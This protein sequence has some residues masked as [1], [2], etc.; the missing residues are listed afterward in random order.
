MA[1]I[2]QSPNAQSVTLGNIPSVSLTPISST[3]KPKLIN[4][5]P[6]EKAGATLDAISAANTAFDE[7]SLKA[8]AKL[9]QQIDDANLAEA[10]TKFQID[11]NNYLEKFKRENA[12]GLD[13]KAPQEAYIVNEHLKRAYMGNTSSQKFIKDKLG[14]E[15]NGL[16]PAYMADKWIEKTE[17]FIATQTKTSINYIGTEI[18]KNKKQKYDAAIKQ[19][20][21]EISNATDD[22][23][24]AISLEKIQ[25]GIN[26]IKENVMLKDTLTDLDTVEAFSMPYVADSV[27]SFI[28]NHITQNPESA[29]A[30][31]NGNNK[32][33]ITGKKGYT[34]KDLIGEENVQKYNDA[35]KNIIKENYAQDVKYAYMS[36]GSLGLPN[37]GGVVNMMAKT[38][39]LKENEKE[40][41]RKDI[42]DR[43]QS[44]I[45][46]EKYY[47]AQVQNYENNE[48]F[49]K[50]ITTYDNNNGISKSEIQD[51]YKS[52]N[53]YANQYLTTV[54]SAKQ[55]QYAGLQKRE[56]ENNNLKRLED[57]ADKKQEKASNLGWNVYSEDFDKAS[58]DYA[59]AKKEYETAQAVIL[60]RNAKEQ[61]A[62]DSVSM[63]IFKDNYREAGELTK[64]EDFLNSG[65][66][67]RYNALSAYGRKLRY[68]S[69]VS[70]L[71]KTNKI[72]VKNLIELS[73]KNHNKANNN[74]RF[75]D[76]DD[77]I[78]AII[79]SELSRDIDNL[80]LGTSDQI[81]RKINNSVEKVMTSLYDNKGYNEL[82]N[83]MELKYTEFVKKN[84]NGDF[85]YNF[86]EQVKEKYPKQYKE[87]LPYIISNNYLMAA[88]VLNNGNN[89]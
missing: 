64:D 61:L 32:F 82:K 60:N 33:Y 30:F 2:P 7:A 35:L 10:F 11:S 37:L 25:N 88:K 22:S 18:E 42:L 12:G 74:V 75:M 86:V 31:I 66:I 71:N 36:N 78:K 89:N 14:V 69:V 16:V 84:K 8:Q 13:E 20:A 70:N 80:A 55:E 53:F 38:G 15:V 77:D 87:L 27:D 57:I 17:P 81:L 85:N 62:F 73:I 19:S 4:K 56:E 52:G 3:I 24:K 49:S 1:T 28:Q 5:A 83:F 79:E 40:T 39:V 23:T 29:I 45:D 68:D 47:N 26:N 9:R 48:M 50:I 76:K 54:S 44:L 21:Y 51:I 34:V 59:K 41:Y 65:S 46:S 63:K 67:N 6:F 43:A 72:D 58:E